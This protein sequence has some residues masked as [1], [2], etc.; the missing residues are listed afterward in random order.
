METV[1]DHT[2][3]GGSGNFQDLADPGC[4]FLCDMPGPGSYD[5]YLKHKFNYG[6]LHTALLRHTPQQ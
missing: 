5:G 2:T 6:L 3:H 4:S 1:T